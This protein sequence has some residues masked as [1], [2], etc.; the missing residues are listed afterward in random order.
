MEA[1]PNWLPGV[2]VMIEGVR[3]LAVRALGDGLL[4]VL[5]EGSLALGDFDDD[6]DIDLII[7][8]QRPLSDAQFDALREGHRILMN[9]VA[10]P[11]SDQ[12]ECTYLTTDALRRHDPANARAAN[13]ERNRDEPLKWVSLDA[14][15]D[16]HRHIARQ[17]GYAVLGPGPETLIDPISPDRLRAHAAAALRHWA[18][19]FV[20]RGEDFGSRGYQS[21][22]VL[23]VCR[24]AHTLASGRIA[25]KR[26]SAVAFLAGG[27]EAWQSLI[28]RAWI[29]RHHPHGP[30]DPDDAA[31]TRALLTWARE[32]LPATA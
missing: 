2:R 19:A 31:A 17:H 9:E 5:V 6:S 21:Y 3:D 26:A 11:W 15:W 22:V 28:A 7:V 8:T 1:R 30:A 24:A 25:S 12:V 23:S 14:G 18:A 32:R 4:A 10:S 29:S 16:I 27:G 13:L 20:D